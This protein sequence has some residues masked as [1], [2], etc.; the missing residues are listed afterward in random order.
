MK[1]YTLSTFSDWAHKSGAYGQFGLERVFDWLETARIERVYWRAFN[2]G[3][4]NYPSKI[5]HVLRGEEMPAWH[6]EG[7]GG[8]PQRRGAMRLIDGQLWDELA[9]AVRI[10]HERGIEVYFWWT[11][12]EEAHGLHVLSDWGKRTDIRMHDRDGNDYPGTCEFGLKD[13]RDLKLGILDELLERN[14]D[15]LLLDF[16]RH[17]ATPSG[18]ARGIHRFGYNESICK[19]F[20]RKFGDDPR[21]LKADD[22]DWLAYKNDYRAKFF[23]TIRRKLGK[24]RGMDVMTV[25]HVDNYKWLC[26]DLPALTRDGT[27]DTVLPTD[28]THC[29]SPATVKR[30]VRDVRKQVRGRAKV[31]ASVQAYWG[32][33]EADSYDDALRAAEHAKA[34]VCVLYES[35]QLLDYDLLT[36]TRAYHLGAP[37]WSRQVR[38]K[39]IGAK[40]K[41]ADWSRAKAHSGFFAYAFSDRVKARVKTTF[42]MLAD[43][44]NLYVRID[45]HGKQQDPPEALVREKKV[46]VDWIGARN[47][48]QF[49]DALHLCLDPGCSRRQFAHFVAQR[50]GTMLQEKRADNHWDG[51]WACEVETVTK[52]HWRATLRIPLSTLNATAAKGERW[53]FQIYRTH[54]ASGEVSSWFAGTTYGIAPAEWGDLEFH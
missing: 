3:R 36:P 23:R 34:D 27:F 12:C 47:Y 43:R 25:P 1:I 49:S 5:A 28:M 51:D 18:D 39:K 30:M 2:G 21:D 41:E 33:L 20:K 26:L 38:V 13:V 17:N 8:G 9:E 4:A 11:L 50:D 44:R 10:G 35:D 46:F 19:A 40:P 48:W 42:K 54:A 53:G 24:R 52:S 32:N 45:A 29:N 7:E 37:R 31:G 14:P 16:I 15:G 6:R 22:P